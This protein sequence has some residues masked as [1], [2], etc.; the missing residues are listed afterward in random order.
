MALIDKETICAEIERIM[1]RAMD[2]EGQDICEYIL[3]FLDTLPEQPVKWSE[4]D[5]KKIR[6]EEYTKGFN[7]AAF[8]GKLKEWSKEDENMAYFVN[9]FLEYHENADPTAKSCKKWFNNRFKSLK[10]HW[11]PSEEQME[12][13]KD[14]VR[15]FKETHFEKFHYKIE[16]LY[17]QL[18]KLYYERGLSA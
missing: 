11:K 6:S 3:E 7:D 17:E 1:S 5:I 18:E 10:P 9:Q 8:G 16:S 14:A 4:E 15:L 12:A 2:K 13:L